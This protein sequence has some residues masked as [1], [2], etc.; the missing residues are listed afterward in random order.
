[1]EN[2]QL[3]C[4]SQ[5]K[6]T[7]LTPQWNVLIPPYNP[8]VQ[9][10]FACTRVVAVVICDIYGSSQS[11]NMPFLAEVTQ[12]QPLAYPGGWFGGLKPPP[13]IPKF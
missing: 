3:M 12:I 6:H 7:M 10:E 11:K 4:P 13:E 1:M 5:S 8:S 9:P 2:L